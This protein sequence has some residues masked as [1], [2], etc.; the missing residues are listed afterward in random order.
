M[1][2][3]TCNCANVVIN[4]TR[5]TVDGRGLE[6]ASRQVEG[7]RVSAGGD[8]EAATSL[9]EAHGFLFHATD[10]GY[11]VSRVP[12]HCVSYSYSS[13]IT[14][15]HYPSNNRYYESRKKTV[16]NKFEKT[17]SKTWSKMA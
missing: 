6:A 13:T 12:L 9:S 2:H 8:K 10:G 7:G 15:S 1:T 14:E 17:W 5:H 4:S 3:T 16:E 11:R